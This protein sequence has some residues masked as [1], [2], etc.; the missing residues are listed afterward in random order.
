MKKKLRKWRDQKGV[1]IV[2]VAGLTV[3][4]VAFIALSVD[5]AHLYVVRNE[6]QNAADAGALAGARRLYFPDGSAINPDANQIAFEAAIVNN[7]EKIAVEV[8]SPTTNNGDVQRGHWSFATQTFSPDDG[9][10]FDPPDLWDVTPAELDADTTWI[11]AVRVRTRRQSSQANSF[12]ARIL[13]FTG[14][15]ASAEAVAY[16][17]F[18]GT[19][20]PGEV[21]QPIAIC[22]ESILYDGEFRCNIGRML[23]SGT[24]PTSHNTAGWTNFT[25][26]PCE[27]ASDAD[28]QALICAGG[29]P[30]EISGGIGIGSTGGVQDN[31]LRALR[32]CFGPTTRT[33]PWGMALPVIECPGNNVSNCATVRG[34]VH[35]NVVWISRNDADTENQFRQE[36]WPPASM[37]GWTCDPTCS[38]SKT[39]RECCWYD[40]VDFFQLKNV[41]NNPAEYAAKSIYFIP[42]CTH[43]DLTGRTGGSL[44]NTLARIP[45]LVN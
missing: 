27:T 11:N 23:N 28:M 32:D 37:G 17:G 22:R 33:E 19:V 25:Q 44:F 14:F 4:F 43:E 13:G 9:T 10:H 7:S 35:V 45:V 8:N 36:D 31:I 40:F 39:P 1:A 38:T 29:N 12:F 18:A 24:N 42:D 26:S 6:L 21:D 16:L 41:D 20:L 3:M 30:Y 15:N 34:I 5:V 2:M